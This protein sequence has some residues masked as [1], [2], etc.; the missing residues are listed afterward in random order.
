MNNSLA[1][2]LDTAREGCLHRCWVYFPLAVPLLYVGLKLQLCPEER[3][4]YLVVPPELSFT[5]SAFAVW[6][7]VLVANADR[8]IKGA[9][10]FPFGERSKRGWV[11]GLILL[12]LGSLLATAWCAALVQKPETWC[13]YL[14]GLLAFVILCVQ[15]SMLYPGAERE[16]D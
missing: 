14:A 3:P 1:E 9:G 5:G 2:R 15:A 4:W 6:G 7:I 10:E 11:A 13:V 8:Q 12:L 16:A